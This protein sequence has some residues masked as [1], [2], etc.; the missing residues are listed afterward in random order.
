IHKQEIF[1]LNNKM[2][3][4]VTRPKGKHFHCI[5]VQIRRANHE[6]T[7]SSCRSAEKIKSSGT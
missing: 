7:A 5:V 1:S 4:V 3:K 6:S 2:R